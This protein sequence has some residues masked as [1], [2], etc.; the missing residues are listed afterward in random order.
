MASFTEEESKHAHAQMIELF[1]NFLIS[2]SV[3]SIVRS[4]H[5]NWKDDLK[6]NTSLLH[7]IENVRM[8]SIKLW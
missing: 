3:E 1:G 8:K 6:K 5:I 4:L 2:N 7:W